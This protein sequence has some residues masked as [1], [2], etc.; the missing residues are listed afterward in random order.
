MVLKRNRGILILFLVCVVVW[1]FVNLQKS[2]EVGD[3]LQFGKQVVANPALNQF[4]LDLFRSINQYRPTSPP[5]NQDKLVFKEKCT[6]DRPISIYEND[7]DVLAKLSYMTLDY[8]FHLSPSQTGNLKTAHKGFTSIITQLFGEPHLDLQ[9][10]LMPQRKGIVTV[11]SDKYI[12]S[13]IA[14]IPALRKAGSKLPIE[15]IFGPFANK[16]EE[17]CQ[18]FLPKYNGRC[19]YMSD[20]LPEY[21]TKEYDFDETM[22]KSFAPLVSDFQNILYMDGNHFAESNIDALFLSEIFL[23]NGLI[24]WPSKW[25]KTI[26][27]AFYQ[28]SNGKIDLNNRTRNLNDDVSSPSR[29]MD[30]TSSETQFQL[31]A[32][33][34]MHDLDGS[35]R[36]PATH[37]GLYMLDKKRHFK[38]LLLSL[39]YRTN[40]ETWFDKM[41]ASENPKRGYQDGLVAAA[42]ALGKPYHQIHQSSIIKGDVIHHTDPIADQEAYS[43]L[44]NKIAAGEFDVKTTDP[45][46]ETLKTFEQMLKTAA[47][48][49][50]KTLFTEYAVTQFN[51]LSLY[52]K[53]KEPGTVT[54]QEQ[55]QFKHLHDA[56]CVGNLE[57]QLIE[58]NPSNY[59]LSQMCQYLETIIK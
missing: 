59:D 13:L 36:D 31:L 35:I 34:P 48:S 44:L 4:Y 2:E 12:L 27:P 40:G 47:G 9:E 16:E 52:V 26:S 37:I 54:K 8:C 57:I 56:L 5:R 51:L 14:S 23:E 21:V 24:L 41:F 17:F 1:K 46:Y 58:Q 50:S 11:A 6:L 39:Y 55:T 32:K 15:V 43:K 28:I 3:D 10:T 29:Y 33:T 7:A 49:V 22:V 18:K 19:I 30:T 25:R 42:H 45:K 20:T 38:T 53:V